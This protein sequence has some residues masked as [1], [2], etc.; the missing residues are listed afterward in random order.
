M[1][2]L[3]QALRDRA[4]RTRPTLV[5]LGIAGMTGAPMIGLAL[6]LTRFGYI[7]NEGQADGVLSA[8]Y[9]GGF[10]STATA[11]RLLRVTGRGKTGAV[12]SYI[13]IVGLLLAAT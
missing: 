12:I 13:Q 7:K 9:M 5:T 10:L 3:R 8:I 11:L 1:S 4:T 2:Q 6:V